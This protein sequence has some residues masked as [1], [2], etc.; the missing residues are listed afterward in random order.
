MRPAQLS[1]G[2]R[3]R[4]LFVLLPGVLVGLAVDAALSTVEARVGWIAPALAILAALI[5]ASLL[6]ARILTPLARAH[7]ELRQRY[8]QVLADAVTDQLTGLGNHRRFQE[9][10]DRE[11][12]EA[13]RYN[14]P[15]SLILLDVDD[16]KTI[17]DTTGHAGG[18]RALARLG[19][20]INA[21]VRRVDRAFR[22]GGDEFAILL[23]HTDAERAR[24]VAMRLLAA[25]V[26]DETTGS[27]G[28]SF[29]AGVSAAPRLALTRAQ[30]YSQA[31]A[32]LYAAK[33]GGRTTVEV[34]EPAM[35]S[36]DAPEDLPEDASSAVADVIARGLLRP[37]YQ[38][39]VELQT[40]AVLG[41]EGLIRP[42]PPAPF[43]NPSSLFA[44]ARVSGRLV[45]LD[46]ACFEI[47][48]SHA[49]ELPSEVYLSVNLSPRT[50]EAP[51][52]SAR[53]LVR[54]LARHR[55]PPERVVIE[56]TEK[57]PITE[58][59]RVRRRLEQCRRAGLRLAADDLGAGNSGLQLLSQLRFD[60]LKVDL[61]LVQRSSPGA[62]SSAVV[63]SVV[64][65]AARTGAVVVAEGVENA[66]QVRQLLA[67]GVN[68]AQGYHLGRP[69]DLPSPANSGNGTGERK[70]ATAYAA[71][72]QEMGLPGS[73][74]G[75]DR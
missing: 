34:F 57:E 28:L 23:S 60:L 37:V 21:T 62:P 54:V 31:D 46:L 67:L 15:L 72:R 5:S 26:H 71:W 55:F 59:E 48:V 70:L 63:G 17:N 40:K 47:I 66:A 2:L 73:P 10:L 24:M 25:A 51:E 3:P 30:L 53:S 33:R 45:A 8:E 1:F 68:A 4:L 14:I 6:A 61:S 32:A 69:D 38:P 39:I 27:A 12:D 64:S 41:Y 29:S 16:F 7:I 75:A 9:E 52:F 13:L 58:L 50:V 74:L 22:I 56:L 19:S 43:T 42:I 49:T 11:V 20:L 18:D 36:E 65:L 35:P 44:A